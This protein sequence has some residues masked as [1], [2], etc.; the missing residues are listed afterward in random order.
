MYC[1]ANSLSLSALPTSTLSHQVA[2]Q[3]K[4]R[5]NHFPACGPNRL[6]CAVLCL[7]IGVLPI[8][9]DHTRRNDQRS[10]L[11]HQHN[12]FI[13]LIQRSATHRAPPCRCAEAARRSSASWCCCKPPIA[14][15]NLTGI[16]VAI[17][18][19]ANDVCAEATAHAERRVCL[20]SLREATSP[21]FSTSYPTPLPFHGAS[22]FTPARAQP[23]LMPTPA[24][25]P[26][27]SRITSTISSSI[28]YTLSYPSGTQP[29]KKNSTAC[30]RSHTT[31]HT[32]SCYA[33]P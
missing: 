11:Q 13:I 8:T 2:R 15:P 9:F 17:E 21:R 19:T 20:M 5:R 16:P 33:F 31:T 28:M 30:D 10:C 14:D 29:G 24:V 22:T 27:Y 32:A 18:T 23:E 26:P 6:V 12:P 7:T 1:V 4:D 25:S 3:R